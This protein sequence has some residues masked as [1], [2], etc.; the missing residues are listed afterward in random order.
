MRN[1][2]KA[3][4]QDRKV[5]DDYQL[6]NIEGAEDMV[7]RDRAAEDIYYVLVERTEGDAARRVNSGEPGEGMQAYQRLYPWFA[8]T[9]GLALTEKTRALMHPTPVKHESEIADALEKWSEK[10]RTLRAHGD[11][12]KLNSAFKVTALRVLMSCKREQFEFLEREAMAKHGDK[13]CDGMFDDLYAKVREYAQ[14][15]RLEELTRKSKGIP[16]T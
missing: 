14:Q 8:G 15:R 11:E 13:V 10:E 6:N 7:D 4:D 16:W 5:L 1:L 9:T 3:L 12:Y 2:N